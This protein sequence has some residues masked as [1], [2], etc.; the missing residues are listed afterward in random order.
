[1]TTLLISQHSS[2]PLEAVS[3]D[4]RNVRYRRVLRE[5]RARQVAA[6]ED[7]SPSS[8][9][10]ISGY[11]PK[12]DMH[13]YWGH[14]AQV[15]PV[16]SKVKQ[17]YGRK[18]AEVTM[19][20]NNNI[21]DLDDDMDSDDPL[22]LKDEPM[23][24]DDEEDHDAE[25]VSVDEESDDE[26][27]EQENDGRDSHI[28]DSDE[29]FTILSKSEED[30]QMILDEIRDLEAAVPE[31]E[32]SYRLVDR[33]GTGTF[34]SVYK[35]VDLFY[36]K[37]DNRPWQCPHPPGSSA[38]PQ[39]V[40]REPGSKI[41]VAIKRIYV[42]SSPER[43]KN[44]IS[45][46]EDCRG[47]R[48]VSQLITAFREKDQ[49]VAIMPYQ[50]NDDFRD[51]FCSLTIEGIKAYFRCL[52]R[53]LRDIHSRQIIHRDVKPANFL[54][55]S[56]TG[57]G[58]LC[59]FGLASRMNTTVPG[60]CL[61][62]PASPSHP[63]GRLRARNE[64][65]SEHIKK[66]QREARAKN[67]WPSDRVGYP[68]NDTRPNSKANRAGTRGFRAPEVLLKCGNQ[69]GAIDVWSAG[70]ILLFVLTK[71]FPLFQSNDDVEALMEIAAIIG[72]KH[73]E[74]VAT[75][76][77]RTFSTNVPSVTAT[78]MTWREFCEKQNPEIYTPPS[79]KPDF[80]P[81]A[82]TPTSEEEHHQDLDNAF[83]LLEKLLH[84][85]AVHRITPRDALYHPFLAQS[86][87]DDEFFP[88]PFGKGVC[89]HLHRIDDVT[90][91]PSVLIETEK[92]QTMKLLENGQGLAI[93][94]QPCEFHQDFV[95]L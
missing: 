92:G 70:S 24:F 30:R 6:E 10:Q 93:G 18:A 8:E 60:P 64:Y 26:Q 52:M 45:V 59:D 36:D 55:D 4:P 54:F 90:E 78:G 22:V 62:L 61:H 57:M 53:A 21:V 23:G 83:D 49:V 32:E 42:T 44:E 39:S 20:L 5:A 48:H 25:E 12:D 74:K 13:A 86:V 91:Q 37:W 2:N 85:E 58:T 41:F 87:G 76:H 16:I 3:S 7:P 43:I 82:D 63:H 14:L 17:R 31:L 29:E 27:E 28:E 47:C 79:P 69:S 34:S 38:H 15:T 56:R 71:K 80:Y 35:A 88:H 73:M 95:F 19:N 9:D 81:H 75:L 51:F 68:Q 72:S 67:H 77:N 33:L 66:M 65:D 89:A 50:R 1:M 11:A 40:A 46:L 94:N 84:P